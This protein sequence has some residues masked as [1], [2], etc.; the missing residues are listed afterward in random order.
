MLLPVY[1]T[2]EEYIRESIAS[3]LRQ[4][5]HEFELLILDDGS[6]EEHVAHVIS[7]FDDPRIIYYYTEH[8]GLSAILNMGIHNSRGKYIARMDSDDIAYPERLLKQFSYLEANQHISI[9]GTSIEIVSSSEIRRHTIRPTL[10]DAFFYCPFFHPT[11]M[12]RKADFEKYN[13]YYDEQC[14]HY[15]DHEL[16]SRALYYLEGR[17]LQEPL[18]AYRIHS[19][20]VSVKY[21][22]IQRKGSESLKRRIVALCTNNIEE[23]NALMD[24]LNQ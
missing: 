14:Q 2:K 17:N 8:K 13:L 1:N 9:L 20:S 22:D 24:L 6:T 7:S 12:W 3:I 23:Q 15:E 16:W 5:Y 10:L 11:V 19:E 4:T 21:N 18:L